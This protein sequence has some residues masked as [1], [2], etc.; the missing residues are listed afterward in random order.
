[1]WKAK[2]VFEER[3]RFVF[4]FAVRGAGAE[5]GRGDAKVWVRGYQ[6]GGNVGTRV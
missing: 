6:D 1:M 3:R 4:V 5:D 2:E